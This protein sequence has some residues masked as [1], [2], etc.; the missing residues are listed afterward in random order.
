MSF[1]PAI[2]L[3][4][5][6][7]TQTMQ[8]IAQVPTNDD[9]SSYGTNNPFTTR[10][11]NVH[12]AGSDNLIYS[13]VSPPSITGTVYSFLGQPAS[14][15]FRPGNNAFYF[16]YTGTG[17]IP[18]TGQPG[19]PDYRIHFAAPGDTTAKL[20]N[21]WLRSMYLAI[22]T[23][24]V[25]NIIISGYRCGMIT[26]QATIT[27]LSSNDAGLFSSSPTD[28]TYFGSDAY[29][30]VDIQF[31]TN[32]EYLDG[33]RILAQ[34]NNI[35]VALDDIVFDLPSDVPP[36]TQAS[37][38]NF[39]SVNNTSTKINWVNGSG[40][41][42]A[43]FV[44][45]TNT[46]LPAPAPGVYYAANNSFG[47]GGQIGAT[48]WYCVYKGKANNVTVTNLGPLNTYKAVAFSCNGTSPFQDYN[49]G[50]GSNNTG[51]FTTREFALPVHFGKINAQLTNCKVQLSFETLT[52]E[53][54]DHF[55]IERSSNGTDWNQLSIAQ[56]KGNSNSSTIYNYTDLFPMQGSNYYRIKQVD[57]NNDQQFSKTLFVKN[58]CLAQWVQVYPNPA[59]DD[60]HIQLATADDKASISLYDMTGKQV[61]VRINANGN[62]RALNIS[63]LSNGNYLLKVNSLGKLFTQ[64]I[65]VTK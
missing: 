34:S 58:D 50:T 52:E 53:A 63:Q 17:T 38:L 39:T 46:G 15:L 20:G 26:S 30:G 40:D 60:L 43:I 24:N 41:S 36:G 12:P 2:A 11:A 49:T 56:G 8:S 25:S 7:L 42:T 61:P 14:A 5:F 13:F 22:G 33:I 62:D 19:S 16:N 44:K 51:I 29:S 10:F 37:S 54:N 3:A 4:C 64:V 6:L 23:G 27:G 21:F 55:V 48:G 45:Q 9:F 47:S 18:G 59:K 57:V 35:P 32:W 65:T 1:K 28:L 31:G